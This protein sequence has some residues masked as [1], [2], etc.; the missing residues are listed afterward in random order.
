MADYDARTPLHLAAGEG[1]MA[2]VMYLLASGA[3]ANPEDRW[4]GRPL[5]DATHRHH[6]ETAKA[7]RNAG[8]THGSKGSVR[9]WVRVRVRVRVW[10]RVSPKTP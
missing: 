2:T 8:A 7:L 5:D 9:V 6:D 3:D 1:R 10:V 4:G